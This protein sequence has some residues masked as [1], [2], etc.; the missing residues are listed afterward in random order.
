ME[1]FQLGDIT[2]TWLDG[3]VI[4]LDGGAMFGVV[5]KP[6]WSKKYPHNDLNQIE[7]RTDPILVQTKGKNLLIDSGIGNRKFSE[8]ALRNFGVA[9]ES[10]LD[11]SLKKIGLTT[12]NIDYVM[13]T[14][15]HFDHACGLTKW[16][17]E[18]LVPTFENA[19]IYST[20]IEWDEMR[21]PNMRSKSTYWKEN[22]QAIKSKVST[23]SKELE[24]L[25]GIKMFHT[26]GHSNGHSIIKIESG[27]ELLIHMGDIMP[28]FAHQNVLWVLAYDDYPM[29]SIKHKQLLMKEGLER[30][31]WYSFYH[32][33]YNRLV[34]WSTD[35]KEIVDS[36]K[37]GRG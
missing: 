12:K 32:D 15:L 26:G 35:G 28:T 11:E 5:P 24:V 13:M 37:R 3:G 6:L 30:G 20:E 4:N 10:K 21:N 36:V 18:M 9:V 1:T 29:D 7:L 8:K 14:H 17:N 27:D 16:K 33:A 23:F 2:L 31:A 19:V 34:K 22:W 25:P